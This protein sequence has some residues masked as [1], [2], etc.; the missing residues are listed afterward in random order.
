M[1]RRDS[2]VEEIVEAVPEAVAY[3]MRKGIQPIA[4][5]APIWGTLEEAARGQGYD[6]DQISAIVEEMR[7]LKRSRA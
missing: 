5:G 4:C 6:D 1:I 2:S 7:E 3:L